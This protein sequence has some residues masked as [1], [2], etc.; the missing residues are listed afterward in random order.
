[1][2]WWDKAAVAVR[3]GGTRRFGFVTTNSITQK[4]SRRVV[5]KHL[6]T[7]DRISL[8]FAIA[9]H[10]WVDEKDGAAV[11]IAMTVAERGKFD[12]RLLTVLDEARAPD[13]IEMTTAFGTISSDLRVG[14]DV[15]RVATRSD[16]HTSELQSL[17]RISYAVFCL[18]K[19]KIH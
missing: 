9:N 13:Q 8:I 19:K 3:K 2:H 16:E 15:T 1:M 12:G 6:E 11:R 18:K 7:A 17:M 10:P 4:F 14:V 5:A